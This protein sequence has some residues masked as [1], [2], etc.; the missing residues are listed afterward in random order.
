MTDG[1]WLFTVF[2]TLYLLECLRW[3]PLPSRLIVEK[4]TGRWSYRRPSGMISARG[5]GLIVLRALPPFRAHLLVSPW[6]FIPRNHHLLVIGEEGQRRCILWSEL[7]ARADGTRVVLDE[8][9]G[10]RLPTETRAKEWSHRLNEWAALSSEERALRFQ[11]FAKRT[12]D[13]EA[14]KQRAA[15]LSGQVRSLNT[16]AAFI[17]FTC[18]G[19]V[20]GVYT[21]FGESNPLWASLILLMLLQLVQSALFWRV[22]RPSKDEPKVGYRFWK[23]LAI[24]LMPHFSIR[25]ADHLCFAADQGDHPLAARELVEAEEYRGVSETFWREARYF[26][27]WATTAEL[28]IEAQ[29][30]AR[31]FRSVGM[32][33]ADLEK[34][35]VREAG[36]ASFCPRCLTQFQLAAGVC[37]DCHDNDLCAFE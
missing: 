13:P 26:K 10:V 34:P 4:R 32:Q 27:G 3:I 33:V 8:S 16:N 12:L 1:Q 29:A 5:L 25:A 17:L 15:R 23:A 19:L 6:R 21:W 28:P 14:M 37:R 9:T 22:T 7:R 35:P 20:T 30:L 36:S 24:A 31:Y 2:A 18:F 11:E